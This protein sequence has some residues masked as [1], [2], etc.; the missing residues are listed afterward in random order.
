MRWNV[1]P[2][3]SRWIHFQATRFE[4]VVIS[5]ILVDI[6]STNDSDKTAATFFHANGDSYRHMTDIK[7]TRDSITIG[8]AVSACGGYD[9]DFVQ[10]DVTFVLYVSWW[11]EKHKKWNAG[12]D[13]VA[14]VLMK[15]EKLQLL[16]SCI[17]FP[18]HLQNVMSLNIIQSLQT[19]VG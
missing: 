19:L 14:H 11:S 4:K 12:I 18:R 2:N 16:I 6:F 10:S 3:S 7:C 17:Q 1:S 9:Y 13:S 5:S 8:M 15:S